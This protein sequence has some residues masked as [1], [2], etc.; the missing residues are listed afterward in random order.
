MAGPAKRF[1][2]LG[3]R[4]IALRRGQVTAVNTGGSFPTVDI[5]L[6]GDTGPE[7]DD[8]RFLAPYWPAVDDQVLLQGPPG[9][10]W[11]VGSLAVDARHEDLY[12]C[13]RT[14]GGQDIADNTAVNAT[15]G[16]VDWDPAGMAD[17][18]T[19]TVIRR[20]GRYRVTAASDFP[21]ATY[22]RV[23]VVIRL[24]G[25]NVVRCNYD[26]VGSGAE[27]PS[28]VTPTMELAVDDVID[29]RVLQ[30]SGGVRTVAHA[31]TVDYLGPTA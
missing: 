7:I 31:L 23:V 10:L 8:V 20:A 2:Q 3:G 19:D 18:T 22:S 15:Y 17:T 28:V 5:R 25:T 13:R 9:D 11:V 26:P 6:D 29:V 27:T 24:N 21:S 16:A 1:E 12:T 30:A 4:Q 14:N